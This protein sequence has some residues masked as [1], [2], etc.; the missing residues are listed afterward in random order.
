[1]TIKAR[2]ISLICFAVFAVCGVGSVGLWAASEQGSALHEAVDVRL[3][4]VL[5]LEIINEAH[6]D[7]A[8]RSLQTAIWEN[9]YSSEAKAHFARTLEKKLEAFK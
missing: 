8:R 1:M 2:L 5:G 3:P 7:V 9:D 4:S 6:T